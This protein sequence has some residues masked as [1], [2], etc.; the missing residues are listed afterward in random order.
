MSAREDQG[1]LV[2]R[3]F[4]TGSEFTGA[5]DDLKSQVSC[6]PLGP[7][8]LQRQVGTR[9]WRTMKVGSQREARALVRLYDR[10]PLPGRF[11]LA[12][13]ADPETGEVK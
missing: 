13:Q 4:V 11:R 8:T 3:T 10:S 7:L 6:R 2:S 1:L 9:P 5:L 12:A